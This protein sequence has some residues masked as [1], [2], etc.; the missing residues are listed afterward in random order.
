MDDAKTRWAANL[1]SAD[2]VRPRRLQSFERHVSDGETVKT[3]SC[4]PAGESQKR[5]ETRQSK[6]RGI[7]GK[8]DK[9]RE[10]KSKAVKPHEVVTRWGYSTVLLRV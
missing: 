5:E 3:M 9:A 4:S 1:G 7:G 10:Q 2:H 8:T 6:H